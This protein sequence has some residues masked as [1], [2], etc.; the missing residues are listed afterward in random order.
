MKNQDINQAEGQ[1]K[2][3]QQDS[4]INP[5]VILSLIIHNWYYFVILIVVGLVLARFY[6]SHTMPVYRVS[7][8]ILINE[9]NERQTLNNEQILQGLGLPGSMAKMDNQIMILGSRALT[10]KA[11][12]ELPYQIEYYFKTLRNTIPIYPD[13]PVRVVSDS[14]IPLPSDVEFSITYLGNNLFNFDCESDFY[15]FHK[16]ATFGQEI[17][18]KDGSFRVSLIDEGWFKRSKDQKLYFVIYSQT[19]LIKNFQNRLGIQLVS[20]QGSIIEISLTGTNKAKDVDFLNK[21]AEIF[22]KNSLDKKNTEAERRIQFIDDQLIG[23]TD[24]LSTTEN[25][26]QQFRSSHKVMDLSAQGQSIITQLTALENQRA[27]LNVDASYYDYLSNYLAK[28]ISGEAPNVPITMG[29]TDPSLTRHVT[30]LASLQ[31]QLSSR[32]GGEM[33]P[34]QNIL[35]QKI[36]NAKDALRET[37]NGLKRANSLELAENQKLTSKINSQAAA[38]PVTERQLLG[39]ERKFNLNNELYTFLLE[40]RAEQQMQKASNM[41]DSEVV[42]PA[43]VSTDTIISPSPAKAYFVGLFSGFAIPLLVIFL[44]FIF[45]KKIKDED[46][47]KMT[48]LP[49]VGKIPRNLEKTNTVV[50]DYPN[51]TI[52]EA[53]RSLRMRMQFF[54]K[55]AKAAVVLVTSSIPGDGKTFTAINLASAYSLLG[56][57]TVLVGFDL[58]K[59]KIY[60]DF[61]LD[62]EKGVS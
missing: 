21:L 14:I 4:G 28:D 32:G 55:D 8:T 5:M 33:N 18:A 37:L 58:R 15:V 10:E 54:T 36:R 62:N 31:D 26:L 25:R 45:N 43:D 23:I 52:A 19:K 29:V 34:L 50:F 11:L 46:I 49:V 48:D 53:Y 35:V 2:V 61:N 60:Q 13:I 6:L 30:E 44:V 38:L 47:E 51:S 17:E 40:T 16:Q 9:E 41:A 1:N 3:T 22:Q 12:K 7:S 59:P 56:K 20:K 27:K 42:D 24:S 39:I 57:K